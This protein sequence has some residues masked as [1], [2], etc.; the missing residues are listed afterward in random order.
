MALRWV[1]EN[2]AQFGGDPKQVTIFGE[3]AGSSSVN[4]HLLLPENEAYFT[5]AIMQVL[6]NVQIKL[7]ESTCVIKTHQP[8]RF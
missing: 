4:Y 8:M 2:I 6:Q 3:S 7:V 5:R 1:H